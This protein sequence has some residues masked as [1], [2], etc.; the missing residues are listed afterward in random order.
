MR[1]SNISVYPNTADNAWAC[2]TMSH[3]ESVSGMRNPHRDTLM[4]PP[5]CCPEL[6]AAAK[7]RKEC[8][9]LLGW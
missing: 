8:S 4:A 2:C 7:S 3:P 6:P 1:S 5:L 9:R